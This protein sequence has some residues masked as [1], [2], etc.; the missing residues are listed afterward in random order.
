MWRRI[1]GSA[2]P[3]LGGLMAREAHP[4]KLEIRVEKRAVE[5]DVE[6]ALPFRRDAEEAGG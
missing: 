4:I 2:G 1:L 5:A 3:S 6:T